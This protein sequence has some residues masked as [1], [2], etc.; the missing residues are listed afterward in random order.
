MRRA[1]QYLK[2]I[3]HEEKLD[4]LDFDLKLK[5]K[6]IVIDMGCGHGDYMIEFMPQDRE[7]LY[8]GIEI[9]R[10]RVGKTAQRLM[11]RGLDHFRVINARGEDSLM[12]LFP[13]ESVDEVHINFPD[14]W[15]KVKQWKNRILRSSFLIQVHRVL[16]P[17]GLLNF[18][19]DVEEYAQY[20]A[21][22]IA[23][24][25]GLLNNYDKDYVQNIYD[26]FPTLFYRKMSP[27]RPINYI[28]F[29][30]AGDI[31]SSL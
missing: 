18:V 13:A 7:A 28:S 15:L 24:F 4:S 23:D 12:A 9:S 3:P 17:G 11:K 27:L 6:K 20:A 30:K 31:F 29:K 16:K 5:G 14:P 2:D 22:T 25:P 26:S 10:K 21:R 19:T 8:I 1:S